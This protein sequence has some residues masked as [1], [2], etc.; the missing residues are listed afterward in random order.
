MKSK[1]L[2]TEVLDRLLLGKKLRKAPVKK[3]KPVPVDGTLTKKRKDEENTDVVQVR[4]EADTIK[5]KR[6]VLTK[7]LISVDISAKLIAEENIDVVQVSTKAITIKS[8][9]LP[10][11]DVIHPDTNTVPTKKPRTVV[12]RKKDKED[13]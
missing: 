11:I 13:V 5:P 3:L 9:T 4:S 2:D 7:K 12:R 1:S 6:R 10:P 8:K